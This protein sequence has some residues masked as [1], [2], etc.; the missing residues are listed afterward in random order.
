MRPERGA[1]RI[2]GM[3]KPKNVSPCLAPFILGAALWI[4]ALPTISARPHKSPSPQSQSA[5]AASSSKKAERQ[6]D[7]INL[8]PAK[9]LLLRPEGVHKADALSHFVEGMALEESGEMEKALAEY[10]KVLNVDPGQTDLASRVAALLARN[11]DF[12]QAIDVLKD[13]IKANPNAPEP[14][15]QLAFIYAKYL[16]RTDQAID[17]ANRAIAIDPR[18]MDAYERL[19]EIS[20]AA[21]DE[22]KALQSLE[23]AAKV[24]SDDATFWT[25]LG[26]LYAAI[27]FKP[28]STPKP[29]EVARVNEIFKKATERAADDPAVLKDIADYYAASQQIKEAIPIYLRLLE[30]QPDDSGAR[31]KLATGFVLTNQRDKAIE[32]L[33]EIIKQHPEKYQPYDL[34]AGLLDDAGRSFQRANQTAQAKAAFRKAA[35]NYEQSTLINPTRPSPYMHLAELLL[36][37]LKENEHAMKILSEARQRF[38]GAPEIIYYLAIA[39]REA[40]HPEQAVATFEEALHEAEGEDA[41]MANARFYFDYGAAAEAAGLYDKAAD[42]F[43][44]SIALDPANAADA[45]NYLAFMWADHSSHLEEAQE[46]IKR[47]LQADPNNGA[48]IDT[49]GWLEFRQGKFEQA[50]TDLLRAAGKMTHDDPIVFEHIGDAYSKL[51]KIPQAMESWQKALALDPQNKRLAEKIDNTKTKMS[52]GPPPNANPI[53]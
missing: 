17:Y 50:L 41:E 38:P 20:L 14:F 12:P 31:E 26:K 15:L 1:I 34:L 25:R 37:P 9:D 22:R 24:R 44:K 32:M 27:V 39:E 48:Y 36:G 5:L 6:D 35:A 21:G 52:K 4:A 46:M 28:D 2:A 33:E 43:K 51:S 30:L 10:Q 8:Q 49:L 19:F 3:M 40:K 11:E 45:Y 16:K 23:R 53:Q 7:S 13:A 18:N 47:A 29:D 42:L